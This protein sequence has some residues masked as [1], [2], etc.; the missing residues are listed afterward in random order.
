MVEWGQGGG[1]RSCLWHLRLAA[2]GAP[3]AAA[4][5]K[6]EGNKKGWWWWWRRRWWCLGGGGG[7]YTANRRGKVFWGRGEKA[8]DKARGTTAAADGGV[9]CT[10]LGLVSSWEGVVGGGVAA[11]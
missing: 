3:A 8:R 1:S 11:V 7:G 10:I 9:F 6:G 2:A 4:A 5:E